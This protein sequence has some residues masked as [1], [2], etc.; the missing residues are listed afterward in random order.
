PLV[1]AEHGDVKL[2]RTIWSFGAECLSIS[3][4]RN[5]LGFVFFCHVGEFAVHFLDAT[6]DGDASAGID[7]G[8]EHADAAASDDAGFVDGYFCLSAAQNLHM[9]ERNRC[10]Y[11]RF[12]A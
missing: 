1:R 8:R 12:L 6:T 7:L 11:S 3:V 10:D 4:L 9:L 2:N 5:N